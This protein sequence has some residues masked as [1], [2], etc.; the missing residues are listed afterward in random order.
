[1][2][3]LGTCTYTYSAV[4]EPDLIDGGEIKY[5]ASRRLV[6]GKIVAA[7]AHSESKLMLAEKRQGLADI[8]GASATNQRH[9]LDAGKA[10]HSGPSGGIPTSVFRQ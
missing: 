5:D 4:R 10:T 6:S 3:E 1:M 8:A 7:T 9:W 2:T